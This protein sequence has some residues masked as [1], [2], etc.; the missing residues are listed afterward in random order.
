MT[1]LDAQLKRQI[2][3]NQWVRIGLVAAVAS[4]I[5]VLIVMAAALAIWPD[6]ALFRPLESYPRAALFTLVPA[7]VA[8]AL[9]AWLVR[10]KDNPVQRFLR[11]AAVVLVLSFIPDYLLPVEH[12]TFL[13]STVAAFLHVVAATVILSILI[14]G[15]RRQTDA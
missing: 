11:I 8:T 12:K 14:M 3:R 10:H 2:D 9:F 1:T 6:I 4:I 5:A 7:V 15:Y 13:A